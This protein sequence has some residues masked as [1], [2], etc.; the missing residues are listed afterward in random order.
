MLTFQTNKIAISAVLAISLCGVAASAQELGGDGPIVDPIPVVQPTVA[1]A[2]VETAALLLSGFHGIADQATFAEQIAE[3]VPVLWSIVRD[4]TRAG[5][6]RDRALIALAYWPDETLR[7][8]LMTM[9][10]EAP[11]DSMDKHTAMTLL[12]RGFGESAL[13]TLVPMLHSAD[14][15]IRL[16]A[17]DSLRLI[18]SPA[19]REALASARSG[20]S[21]RLVLE[22]IDQILR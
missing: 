20:E 7:A 2:D 14:L 4:G 8:H 13:S 1:S 21:H 6:M 10:A 22:A 9:L 19:A 5:F 12:A 15:Q 3:P 11:D 16:S 18:G 17:V